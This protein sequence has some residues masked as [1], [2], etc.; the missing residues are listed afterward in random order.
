LL[1]ENTALERKQIEQYADRIEDILNK[2]K[3]MFGGS[4]GEAGTSD[5]GD[6]KMKLESAISGWFGNNGQENINFG[7]LTGLFQSKLDDQGSSIK[8]IKKRIQNFDKDSLVAAITSNT[9]IDQRDI[10]K[11]VQSYDDARNNVLQKIRSEERRVGKER[12]YR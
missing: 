8:T 1:E 9:S 6:M 4:Y 2:I 11:V 10:D 3:S 7:M 12:G 5:F